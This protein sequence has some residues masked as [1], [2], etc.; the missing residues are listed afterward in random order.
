VPSAIAVTKSATGNRDISDASDSRFVG[1]LEPSWVRLERAWEVR[2]EPVD[3]KADSDGSR[4]F[5][6][7]CCCAFALIEIHN[8]L[9]SRQVIGHVGATHH[10]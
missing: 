6:M 7:H 5:A 2:W 3:Q 4:P 8:R 9:A 10:L 1:A